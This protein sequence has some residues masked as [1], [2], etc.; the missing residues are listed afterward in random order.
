[1]K[2]E[3]SAS[4]VI[5][6]QLDDMETFTRS[7]GWDLDFRQIS[8]GKIGI[9]FGFVANP[10][11]SVLK[12]GFDQSV[13]QQGIPP[14][15]TLTFGVHLAGTSHWYGGDAHGAAIMNFNHE[16][17][18]DA[19]TIPGFSAFTLSL[20][21]RFLES[22]A[23]ALGVSV[24]DFVFRPPTGNIFRRSESSDLLKTTLLDLMD[25]GTRVLDADL[26]TEVVTALLNAAMERTGNTDR[27][28]LRTRSRAVLTALDYIE[29]NPLEAITVRDI[30]ENSYVSIRTLNRAF[31]ERF[32]VG[33]K[34]YV[35]YRRLAGVNKELLSGGNIGSIADV[36]I[37]WGFWHTGQF[38][39][40]YQNL[41]GE[42]PSATLKR[43]AQIITSSADFS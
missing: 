21:S 16:S 29:S 17:G 27:A 14:N 38:A 36:A 15:G 25:R 37:K 42:L 1:M 22:T 41:F 28:P 10:S 4:Q 33:P 13:H 20:S 9:D 24:P 19:V 18:F 35:R 40:D 5:R 11:L 7:S 2:P 23:D 43:P 30:C 12:V 31:R 6:A 8:R 32:G 34:T 26:E 39:R 3:N